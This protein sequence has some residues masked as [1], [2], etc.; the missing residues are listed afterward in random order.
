MDE[1]EYERLAAVEDSMWWFRALHRILASLATR[2]SPLPNGALLDAGCGTGGFLR[3]LE[4]QGPGRLLV[5]IDVFHGAIAKARERTGAHVAVGSVNEMPLPGGYFDCIVSADVLCHSAI[6][7][8]RALDEL[9]RCLRPGGH[10][11]LQLP[12]YQWLSSYH[13]ERCRQV[14][15]FTRGQLARELPSHGFVVRYA[16]YWNTVLFP[17]VVAR[18]KLLPAPKGASDVSRFN[19]VADGVFGAIAGLEAGLIRA[20]MRLPFGSSVVVVAMKR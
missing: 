19:T 13:D 17:L 16:T 9:F 4:R 11:I 6:D 15:R 20:G 18:R 1:L 8:E 12:A 7:Y 3:V 10:L 14:R 5:G 2:Y